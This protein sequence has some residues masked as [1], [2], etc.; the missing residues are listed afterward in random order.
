MIRFCKGPVR[1][2]ADYLTAHLDM[3]GKHTMELYAQQ[4]LNGRILDGTRIVLGGSEMIQVDVEMHS[5]IPAEQLKGWRLRYQVW[6][7]DIAIRQNLAT[8]N[9]YDLEA[10]IAGREAEVLDKDGAIIPQ[11]EFLGIISKMAPPNSAALRWQVICGDDAGVH[12]QLQSLPGRFLDYYMSYRSEPSLYISIAKFSFL[13]IIYRFV[14]CFSLKV[15][16]R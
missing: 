12:L 15:I 4:R 14:V 7:R 5:L 1:P 8:S 11:N 9:W 3:P 10:I 13:A 6:P 16:F 2:R